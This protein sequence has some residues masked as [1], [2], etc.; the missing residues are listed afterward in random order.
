MTSAWLIASAMHEM[1]TVSTPVVTGSRKEDL[2]R[3]NRFM[4]SL[5]VEPLH[6]GQS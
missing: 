2:F 4:A 1:R 3:T 5:L 6:T